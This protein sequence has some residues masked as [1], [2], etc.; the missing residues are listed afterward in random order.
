MLTLNG[1]ASFDGHSTSLNMATRINL[2]KSGQP[3]A[4]KETRESSMPLR[5]L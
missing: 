2:S 1:L 5:I 3:G 4:L